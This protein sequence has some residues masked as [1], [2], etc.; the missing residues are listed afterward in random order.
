MGRLRWRYTHS[1]VDLPYRHE[2]LTCGRFGVLK[3]PVPR[4]H[5]GDRTLLELLRGVRRSD[6]EPLR[7]H[8]FKCTA[9][10]ERARDL[11]GSAEG[12][13]HS[14]NG[15]LLRMQPRYDDAFRVDLSQLLNWQQVLDDERADAA[16]LVDKLLLW[17]PERSRLL[18]R[19]SGRFRTWGLLERLLKECRS[20]FP[21]DLARAQISA[22][23]ALDLADRIDVGRYGSSRVEDMRVRAWSFLGNVRRLQMDWNGSEEAFRRA[24]V[25]LQEGTGDLTERAHYQDLKA[26]LRKDQKRLPEAASLLRRAHSTFLEAG[27]EHLAGRTLVNL[28]TVFSRSGE[29]GQAVSILR[30]A[31]ELLDPMLEHRTALCAQH[32]LIGTLCLA[33]RVLEAQKVMT[34]ARPLYR[35]FPDLTTQSRLAWVEGMLARALGRDREA[36]AFLRDAKDG[37]TSLQATLDVA[38]ISLDLGSLYRQRS[39]ISDIPELVKEALP[40]FEYHRMQQEAARMRRLLLHSSES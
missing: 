2:S 6:L 38:F 33:G 1:G 21:G 19:N 22:E 11:L 27:E 37:F 13:Q 5:P 29:P 26:S 31:V 24:H 12:P 17:P 10:Q 3:S 7:Q 35:E 40:V 25:H 23:L 14:G 4:I 39:R 28:S 34:Q 36:E 15:K 20:T 30:Q 8:L 9:C 16:Q 32:N 18:L